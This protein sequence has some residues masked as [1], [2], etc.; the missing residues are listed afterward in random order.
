[1]FARWLHPLGESSWVNGIAPG[2]L[3]RTTQGLH[4]LRVISVWVVPSW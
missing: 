1:M 2:F 4:R 3:G